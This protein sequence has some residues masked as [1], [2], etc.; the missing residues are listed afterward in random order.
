MTGSGCR[1]G[2]LPGPG[3][4]AGRA[5]CLLGCCRVAGRAA[6]GCCRVLPAGGLPGGC[7]VL[8]G[9]EDVRAGTSIQAGA[10]GCCRVRKEGAAA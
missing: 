4:G 6:A 3:G 5:G 10:A 1:P 9:C 8:L 7:R 2:W